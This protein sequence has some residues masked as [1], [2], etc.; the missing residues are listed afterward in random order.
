M[1]STQPGR[2]HDSWQGAGVADGAHPDVCRQVRRAP[3]G[4][5]AFTRVFKQAADHQSD[6]RAPRSL[7]GFPRAGARTRA[8][9]IPRSRGKAP[10]CVGEP[11]DERFALRPPGPPARDHAGRERR[12]GIDAALEGVAR[13]SAHQVAH[14]LAPF[15][16]DHLTRVRKL[17]EWTTRLPPCCVGALDIGPFVFDIS[18]THISTVE[19]ILGGDAYRRATSELEDGQGTAQMDICVATLKDLVA[20]GL[21]GCV[22]GAAAGLRSW[23]VK[24][25]GESWPPVLD[26]LG[27]VDALAYPVWRL[28]TLEVLL[29]ALPIQQRESFAVARQD[30]PARRAT[31]N[32]LSDSA[33]PS[34][35]VGAEAGA[36]RAESDA[37][38]K[39]GSGDDAPIG[40]DQGLGK[41]EDIHPPEILALPLSNGEVGV[42]AV[43]GELALEIGDAEGKRG[44]AQGGVFFIDRK[45]DRPR[46]LSYRKTVCSVSPPIPPPRSDLLLVVIAPTRSTAPVTS[47][48]SCEAPPPAASMPASPPAP[49]PLSFIAKVRRRLAGLRAW[50]G[51]RRGDPEVAVAV[52]DAV[53][54]AAAAAEPVPHRPLWRQEGAFSGGALT[55][56]QPAAL[57]AIRTTNRGLHESSSPPLPE[58]RPPPQLVGC[59][60][61]YDFSHGTST[62]PPIQES[63]ITAESRGSSPYPID[64]KVTPASSR[65]A[66]FA[67]VVGTRLFGWLL[68]QSFPH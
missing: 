52:P 62:S 23:K 58:L 63:T 11:R 40:H 45:R 35:T 38:R 28:E 44:R 21:N 27:R 9:E 60:A 54:E 56:S 19:T 39:S 14:G 57:G 33:V 3:H 55:G 13:M 25:L 1:L 29:H 50:G 24:F 22:G 66:Q 42:E 48:S 10:D 41:A 8:R 49:P 53:P 64:R 61:R 6:R 18:K 7:A 4:C 5:R 16:R 30:G 17:L 65:S 12:R 15:L 43:V 31:T 36:I 68:P 2:V 59:M 67:N 20:N 37:E 47:T 51:G 46:L 32:Q 26:A 34:L